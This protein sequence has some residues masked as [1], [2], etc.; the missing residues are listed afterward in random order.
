MRFSDWSR[1]TDCGPSRTSGVT[2]RPRRAG[3]GE[4]H[5]F[6]VDSIG[7][8]HGVAC[9]FFGFEAH[10]GPGIA[11]NG[12]Y[13]GDGFARIGEQLNFGFGFARYALCVAHDFGKWRV[14]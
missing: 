1:T 10:A 7:L 5:Q 9:G 8:E 14:L 12:L 4:R 6:G 3:R 2:S 11:V 13:A